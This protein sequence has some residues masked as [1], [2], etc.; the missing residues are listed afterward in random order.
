MRTHGKPTTRRSAII[1]TPP[2]KLVTP[3]DVR[4]GNLP[5]TRDTYERLARLVQT[6]GAS[7]SWHRRR[8]LDLYL[9]AI[10]AHTAGRG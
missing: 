1:D 5:V 3:D 8:A 6:T 9:D 4:L 10:D 7:G 2:L